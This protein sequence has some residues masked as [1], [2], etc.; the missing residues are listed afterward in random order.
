MGD[1]RLIRLGGQIRDEISKM[2]A[3]QTIKDPR[4]STF[5]SIN[6]VE[7]SGDL[8][9]AKVYVSSFMD[10]AQTEKGVKG[11]QSAAGF[12]QTQLS[13]KL[14]L[15]QFPKLEFVRDKSIQEGFDMVQKL[16]ALEESE[17]QNAREDGE[18]LDNDDE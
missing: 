8:G 18:N 3:K 10:D 6:L 15:R 11:L 13:K 14:R 16:T 2:I 5:L 17:K 9:F 4:V 1:F 12:I 7:L